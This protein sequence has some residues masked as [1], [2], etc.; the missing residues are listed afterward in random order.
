LSFGATSFNLPPHQH[1]MGFQKLDDGI[2]VR[3]KGRLVAQGFCQKE[4]IYYEKI[5]AP[6]VRLEATRILLA[7]AASKCFKLFQMNV[8]SAF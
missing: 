8:K 5:F 3:N 6:V 4:G 7:F 1:Q 2:M